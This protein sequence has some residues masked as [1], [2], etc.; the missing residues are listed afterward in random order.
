MAKAI[1][2]F[3][4]TLI[5]P[6]APFDLYL[7]GDAKALGDDEKKGLT[8][9]LDKGCAACHGGLNLGGQGYYPFGVVKKPGAEILPPADKGRYEVTKT[10][11]DEYVFKSPSLRN[12]ALTR[13]YFHSGQVWT[14]EQAV[15]VMGSAQLGMELSDEESAQITAFLET[16]TGIQ[17]TVAHPV[18]PATTDQTPQPVLK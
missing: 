2:A 14:L 17:P 7:K 10:A 8:L 13:P 4:A 5:T 3:E 9:F 18:L 6:G 16:L 15:A 1:E 11:S 12:I